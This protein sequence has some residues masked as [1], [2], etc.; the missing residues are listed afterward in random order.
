MLWVFT[1]KTG[2]SPIEASYEYVCVCVCVCV[3]CVLE[4]KC[5]CGMECEYG[6]V[7]V[8]IIG[9]LVCIDSIFCVILFVLICISIHGCVCVYVCMAVCKLF[10][11]SICFCIHMGAYLSMPV[12]ECAHTHSYTLFDCVTVQVQGFEVKAWLIC[13]MYKSIFIFQLSSECEIK[14]NVQHTW[15]KKFISIRSISSIAFKN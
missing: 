14:W 1:F 6:R 2:I 8:F 3:K 5:T 9:T 10:V 12:W 11:Y 13:I 4:L 7:C 15:T